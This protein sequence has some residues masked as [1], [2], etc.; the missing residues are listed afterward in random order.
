MATKETAS[1]MTIDS[2]LVGH[3]V[4]VDTETGLRSAMSHN[5]LCNLG[6]SFFWVE[7][8]AQVVES[9]SVML[10]RLE[11]AAIVAGRGAFW[12]IAAS[13]H[14]REAGLVNN[15]TESQVHP[16]CSLLAMSSKKQNT[17][18]KNT[19]RIRTCGKHSAIATH[20]IP[21]ARDQILWCKS[22]VEGTL[23]SNTEQVCKCLCS[24]YS[25]A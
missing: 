12:N 17:K 20:V 4:L 7:N 14:I 21:V 9:T 22:L 2:A 19:Q 10:S 23:G 15:A 1:G 5:V 18:T 3:E 25:P 13:G 11:I 6:W 24:A 8:G 16:C